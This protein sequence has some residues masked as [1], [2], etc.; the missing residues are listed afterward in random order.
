[1]ALLDIAGLTIRAGARDL[2]R[3]VSLTLQPGEVLGLIGESGAGKS[4]IGLAALGHVRHGCHAAAGRVVFDGT[5]LLTAPTATL[6]RLRGGS[7]AYVAQ[8]AAAAFNPSYRLGAQI[9]EVLRRFDPSPPAQRRARIVALLRR[10]GLPDPERFFDRYPHQVSG[11]QLQRAMTAMAMVPEPRLVVFDEPTTALDVTTQLG[12]LAAI[13]DAIRI[14]GAAALYISHDL[15]LVSQVAD[16]ILVLRHGGMVEEGAARQVVERPAQLYTRRLLDVARQRPA[17][18]DGAPSPVVLRVEGLGFAFGL[19]RVLQDIGLEVRRGRT[20]AVV[21]ESG[22][23][24]STLARI[25]AGLHAP[26]E[27]TIAFRD[28][29]LPPLLHQRD[30][31][32]LRRIQMVFQS[33]DTALNPTQ[34][35]AQ[36]IGRPLAFYG[37]LA[38]AALAQRVEDLL[39]DVE[40]PP[41]LA[42]RRPPALSGG[43]KQRVAIARAL[44][45]EP[46]VILCDEITASLDPLVADGVI[47]LLDRLRRERG[48]AYLFI[49]HDLGLV[50]SLADD[51][52]VMEHGRIVDAGSRDEVLSPPWHPTTELLLASQPGTEAGWLDAALQRRA[53]LL[54]ADAPP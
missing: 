53:R 25:I 44:A 22:S 30:K 36:I 35:V 28:A 51:V 3:D 9:D 10:F 5:D 13:R 24:K 26:K 2:V 37:G 39:R 23:G 15:A 41:D 46:D 7:I 31:E 17:P 14:G 4:T 43:Q 11:G 29:P 20:L 48:V 1:M 21:G 45:A 50:R 47:R 34:T 33:A 12:V 19:F 18:R 40:L 38:G 8:S 27:G 54:G 49:T 6:R 32:T 52:V 42:T 16:R